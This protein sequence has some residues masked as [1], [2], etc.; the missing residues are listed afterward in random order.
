MLPDVNGSGCENTDVLNQR[1]RV[2]WELSRKALCPLLFGR[3][4]PPYELVL[5]VA[6]L[7]ASGRPL[8][9]VVM[10]A[11]V[12]PPRRVDRAGGCCLKRLALAERQFVEITDYQPLR[13]IL[14]RHGAL[15]AQVV[16][17]LVTRREVISDEGLERVCIG[18]QF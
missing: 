7:R 1:F 18:D 6:V 14:R 9:K 17:V 5:F 8:C 11:T 15:Q 16:I 2:R 12:Q 3:D 13:N 4:P 10:P